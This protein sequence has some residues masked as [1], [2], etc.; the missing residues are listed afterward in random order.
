[1]IPDISLCLCWAGAHFKRELKCLSLPCLEYALNV[2]AE[3]LTTIIPISPGE[4]N[5]GQS[6]DSF[7]PHLPS[8]AQ[9]S[10]WM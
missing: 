4:G 5:V 7:F 9:K 8:L 10:G 2:F 3:D 6:T 1:M